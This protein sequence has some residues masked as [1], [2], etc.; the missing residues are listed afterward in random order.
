MA[1][2]SELHRFQ[3][4]KAMVEH[5]QSGLNVLTKSRFSPDSMQRL[6]Q[7]R[8]STA[9]TASA[10]QQWIARISL[11][12]AALS[13]DAKAGL[14]RF[15][16]AKAATD[17]PAWGRLVCWNRDHF[18]DCVVRCGHA[19]DRHA[20]LFLCALQ[21]PCVAHWLH[22]AA[23]EQ[24]GSHS[25]LDLTVAG[26]MKIPLDDD[27]AVWKHCWSYRLDGEY[28]L[29]WEELP[30][31]DSFDDVEVIAACSLVGRNMVVSDMDASPWAEFTA[32][33]QVRGR[34]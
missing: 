4:E 21:N 9:L 8:Q 13:P 24:T 17:A 16:P 26:C 33:C 19:A 15:L 5:D 28:I 22:L 18:Q 1:A 34:R 10:L 3:A 27:V 25:E 11:P 12:P 14:E 30:L 6:L 7:H 2:Q 23:V 32:G 29:D 31:G 20:F